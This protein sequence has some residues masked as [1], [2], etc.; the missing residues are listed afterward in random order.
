M[1]PRRLGGQRFPIVN[2]NNRG[3]PSPAPS[4][5]RHRIRDAWSNQDGKRKTKNRETFHESPNITVYAPAGV[6]D[7]EVAA[8]VHSA[9]VSRIRW[10]RGLHASYEFCREPRQ[11]FKQFCL[12]RYD[13]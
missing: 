12:Q 2:S 10:I 11:F 9:D 1:T 4:L 7:A 6:T 5:R 13:G 3:Q 8:A